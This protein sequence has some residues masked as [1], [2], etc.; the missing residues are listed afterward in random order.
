LD[1]WI[2][3]ELEKKKRERGSQQPLYLPIE[4]SRLTG[5]TEQVKKEK[6]RRGS[7]IIDYEL[8]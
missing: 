5:S 4:S 1:L 3:E 2:I 8:R 6:E 7:I